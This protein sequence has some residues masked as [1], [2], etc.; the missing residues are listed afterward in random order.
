[1]ASEEQLG[2][3]KEGTK[4]WNEWR[5]QNFGI[6]LQVDL[7]GAD[8]SGVDLFQAD[9]RQANLTEA[10]LTEADLTQADLQSAKLSGA[11]LTKANLTNAD[12]SWADLSEADLN[13]AYFDGAKLTRAKLSGANLDGVSLDGVIFSNVDLSGCKNLDS[14]R[15]RGPSYVDISTLQRSGRLPLAFLRGVGLP[16]KLIEY[17]PSILGE[18]SQHYSCFISYSSKDEDFAQRLHADLQDNR[19]RC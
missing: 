1:M 13:R 12:L 4:A 11:H 8:L 15:H 14:I 17:L 6:L 9:L 5:E 3:L 18:A 2:I 10:N 19:V 16:E 7:S